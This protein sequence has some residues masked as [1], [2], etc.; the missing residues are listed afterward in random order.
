MNKP[1][2]FTILM[3]DKTRAG[4]QSAMGNVDGLSKEYEELMEKIRNT[5]VEMDRSGNSARRVGSDYGNLQSMLLKLGGTTA[6]LGLGK[7]IIDV[8]SEIEMLE[9]S[10]EILAGSE[11]DS[12]AML[13][14]LK[15][16]AV[17]SPLKL[18]DITNGAQMLMGFN[19]AGDEAIDVIKQIGDVSMGNS[20]KFHSLLLAFSQMS[21]LGKVVSQDLR[22]MATA[23]FNPLTEIARTTGKTVQEVTR[24]L[25]NGAISVDMVKVAFASAT[26]EGGKYY[27]MTEKQAEGLEGLKASL[28]DAWLNI[29]NE[30]GERNQEMI[31]S[32]YR[33][34]T[35]IVQN[36][37][38]IGKVLVALVATYG[39]YRTAII[40]T[41][42]AENLRYQATLAQ[43]A[44]MTKMQAITDI[45]R[46]KTA[47]LNKVLL[48]N[49]YALIAVAI[50]GLATAIWALH[51]STTA[52]EKAYK[53]LNDELEK[54]K[55]KKDALV[56]KSNSLISVIKDETQTI[57]AQTKAWKEL[58]ETIP[59]VF[60]GMSLDE[61][62]NLS[63]DEINTRVN[64]AMDRQEIDAVSRAYE[65][66]QKEVDKLKRSIDQMAVTPSGMYGNGGVIYALNKELKQA[67]ADLKVTKEHID[68][69]NRTKIEAEFNAKPAEERLAYHEKELEALIKERDQLESILTK[70]GE[71]ADKWG[72]INW[73][74]AMNVGK[75]EGVNQ[76]MQEIQGKINSIAGT[77]SVAPVQNKG[78]WET[79]KQE[80]EKAR[81]ALDISKQNSDEWKKYT[82]EIA[83]AQKQL[84]KY[85]TSTK[86][87]SAESAL[88]KAKRLAQEQAD[89]ELKTINDNAKAD[90]EARSK[91]IENN[92]ALLSIQEDGF[93]K[94]QKQLDL[95][96]QKRLLDID[97]R[98]RELLQKQQE[99]ERNAWKLN[100][101]TGTFTPETNTE[102]DLFRINPEAK[103]EIQK[104]LDVAFTVYKSETDKLYKILL[105]KYQD[106]ATRR[107]DVEKKF[108]EDLNK[109]NEL[110]ESDARA[111]AIAELEKQRK[112]SIEAIN[113]EEAEETKKTAD[114]FVRLFTDASKQSAKQI[115]QIIDEVQALYDYLSTTNS[116]DI[117]DQF[118]FSAEQLNA[119]KGD[120]EQLK[121]ILDGLIAKKKDLAGKSE[122]EAF[123]Q[124][125]GDAV[126][127]IQ[128]GGLENIGSG[129]SDIGGAVQSVMP[130]IEKFGQDLGAIFGD[131]M[132]NDIKV[133]TDL[134]GATV[135]V[136]TGVGKIMSGDVVG[137]IQDVISGLAKVFSMASA[138]EKRHQQALEEI[139]QR[140]LALQREYNLLLLEQ[141]LL[142]KEASSIF[143]EKEITK[144][145]GAV[146][147]YRKAIS[148]LAEE[149]RGEAPNMLL[150]IFNKDEYEKQLKEYQEGLK[151]L[152]DI[153]AVTGHKKT[154]LF[155]WGSGKDTYSS[156]MDMY[157]DVITEEGKLNTARIQSILDTQKLSDES[158][159]YL[160]NLLALEGQAEAAQE[161]LRG[162]LQQTF[163]SLGDGLMDS[164]V[165]S[166]QD[167]GINAWENFGKAGARVI[168]QLGEQLAYELFFADKF[169]RL[170]DDLAAIYNTTS[171]PQKIAQ[172]QMELVGDFYSTIGDEMDAAAA[173]MEEWKRNA[174][175]H[176]F[177]L[178][179]D[180]ASSQSGK[181]GAFTMMTQDQGAKLEGLFTSVQ[182]HVS[183]MDDKM[184]DLSMAM[185]ESIDILIRIE[186]N[187]SYCRELETIRED[188]KAIIR[189]GLR[190]R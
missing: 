125:I 13:K 56:N 60:K 18:T 167:K 15:E 67:E 48:A 17:K 182:N 145:A 150:S 148:L 180:V 77:S 52:E 79:K 90:L 8:R 63:P 20:A 146:E 6:L 4:I 51:D 24:D 72:T 110:P 156:I 147:N 188:I 183:S 29:L 129:V 173:F 43:M 133:I 189:D 187:T 153:E 97:K 163:G 46:V 100:G 172:R 83:D 93:D 19:V 160:E 122:F 152:Y 126:K 41:S 65:N 101:G 75:L 10:F 76:K 55:E 94:Q 186:E 132:A 37:E 73:E 68:E 159:A 161:A 170:Q 106:Y 130:S 27:R 164:I 25:E 62:R 139:A 78:F 120:A 136:G 98:S 135:E 184:S 165:A 9:K 38:K 86:T 95:N 138:A 70:S 89:L 140:K 190:V 91:E 124:S 119:F 103:K 116:E 115:R 114:L 102:A 40:V 108:Q 141:N 121:A 176:G 16:I 71:V 155:G 113:K 143:G 35:S 7:E 14:E 137:G 99:A 22:Q 2:E 32:G 151:G 158:R 85:S 49:P 26:A 88:Q 82:R 177:D 45:L 107:A 109:L 33:M 59:D 149:M 179:S 58:Q 154:G 131:D 105:D 34:T 81:D 84:A 134:L 80:A 1:V 42:V 3:R 127:K 142:L 178:W 57:Y 174:S 30:T 92:Q 168:E 61:F 21:S 112:N 69:I 175:E 36:Y 144:A 54:T 162:Y 166:I 47:A 96:H 66:A 117:T 118:G 44:G 128:K 185:Y 87:G 12:A 23:G 50:V 74:T 5:N 104:S 31:S 111:A 169:A 171:D 157:D 39:A 53:K 64:V 28:G 181:A 123:S 11:A